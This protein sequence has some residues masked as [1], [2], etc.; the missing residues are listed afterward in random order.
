MYEVGVFEETIGMSGDDI[1]FAI[2]IPQESVVIPE[3]ID[4][5]RAAL[6]MQTDGLEAVGLTNR[7][8]GMA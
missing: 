8:L 7:Y 5:V 3:T 6:G 4:G 2:N 1:M